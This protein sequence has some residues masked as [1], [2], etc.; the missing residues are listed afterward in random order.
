MVLFSFYHA[1]SV[2]PIAAVTSST[3]CAV[4]ILTSPKRE[5]FDS[6]ISMYSFLLFSLRQNVFRGMCDLFLLVHDKL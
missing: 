4:A 1:Q 3:V 6:Y 2:L 5:D